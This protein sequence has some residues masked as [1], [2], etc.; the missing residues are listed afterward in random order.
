MSIEEWRQARETGIGSSDCAAVLGLSEYRT[1][2]DVYLEKI[3]EK[4]DQEENLKM[5]FGLE[6]EP[7]VA[8]MFEQKTGLTVRNDFKIRIHPVYPF[9]IANLD[10]TILANNG[11][12][13]GILEIKKLKSRQRL[14]PLSWM[15]RLGDYQINYIMLQHKKKPNNIKKQDI[16]KAPFAVL[17]Q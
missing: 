17:R 16:L 7:I 12:G 5:K 14:K 9:L 15:L 2:L 8:R 3:G 1:P 10:R 6:A 4:P 11:R 13:V